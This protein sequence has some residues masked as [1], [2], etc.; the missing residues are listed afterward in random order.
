MS[1]KRVG[2]WVAMARSK[3]SDLGNVPQVSISYMTRDPSCTKRRHLSVL[4]AENKW[5]CIGCKAVSRTRFPRAQGCRPAIRLQKPRSRGLFAWECGKPQACRPLLKCLMIF[6][7]IYGTHISTWRLVW[8]PVTYTEGLHASSF[9]RHGKPRCP[10]LS[11]S[12]KSSFSRGLHR[13]HAMRT[14]K[15]WQWWSSKKMEIFPHLAKHTQRLK[16]TQNPCWLKMHFGMDPCK[17]P[18]LDQW[19]HPSGLAWKSHHPKKAI[20]LVLWFATA[21][22][23]LLKRGFACQ[24]FWHIPRYPW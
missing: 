10:N 14:G 3:P 11:F 23:K 21:S 18:N 12:N 13:L 8:W 22:C 6:K 9:N 24:A 17:P 5:T 7:Y 4:S 15:W 2:M 1:S 16:Q 20:L 19:T